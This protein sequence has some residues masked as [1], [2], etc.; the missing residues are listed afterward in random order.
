MFEFREN[1]VYKL[2]NL[3]NQMGINFKIKL[4]LLYDNKVMSFLIF[5]Y[6]FK[7]VFF[8]TSYLFFFGKGTCHFCLD[9]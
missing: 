4:L 6:Y 7:E 2:V 1:R 8:V 9:H 5:F 3:N